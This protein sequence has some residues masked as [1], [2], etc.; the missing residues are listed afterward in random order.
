MGVWALIG[1]QWQRKGCALKGDILT[2]V[3]IFYS[4]EIQEKMC[5]T[6]IIDKE[7]R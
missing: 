1:V 6:G 3:I 2:P 4:G 7:M 5:P